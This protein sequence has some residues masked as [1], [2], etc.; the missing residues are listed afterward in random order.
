LREGKG[1]DVSHIRK[2]TN[3]RDTKNSRNT[4]KRKDVNNSRIPATAEM[5]AT[6]VNSKP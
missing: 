6:A 5:Q 1:R 4:M 2:A 3:K